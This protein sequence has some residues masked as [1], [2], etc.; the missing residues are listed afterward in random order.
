MQ[1]IECKPLNWQVQKK[2][3]RTVGHE[4]NP[5]FY[6]IHVGSLSDMWQ[7]SLLPESMI[8]SFTSMHY[9]NDEVY[10][11]KVESIKEASEMVLKFAKGMDQLENLKNTIYMSSSDY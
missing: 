11:F 4:V 1:M 6:T 8:L 3:A 9:S 2:Y 10:R 7:A 5:E